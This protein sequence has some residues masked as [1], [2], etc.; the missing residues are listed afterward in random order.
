MSRD[1][2]VVKPRPDVFEIDADVGLGGDGDEAKAGRVREVEPEPSAEP[3]AEVKLAECV[4]QAP[5][6]GDVGR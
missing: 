6:R 5:G 3:G 1:C 4:T 2:R